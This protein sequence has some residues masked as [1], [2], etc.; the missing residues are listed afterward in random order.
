MALINYANVANNGRFRNRVQVAL[1]TKAQARRDAAGNVPGEEQVIR[2]VL[3]EQKHVTGMAWCLVALTPGARAKWDNAVAGNTTGGVTDWD[4][5][6]DAATDSDIT[7]GV[8]MLW[9]YL[10]RS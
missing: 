7:A 1:V 4:S 2:E 3:L 9:K 10:I 6:S 8:D 5:V